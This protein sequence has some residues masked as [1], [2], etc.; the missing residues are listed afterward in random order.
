MVIIFQIRKLSLR[1][2]LK[3][4]GAT[5]YLILE[6]ALKPMIHEGNPTDRGTRGQGWSKTMTSARETIIT[7]KEYEGTTGEQEFPL[8][9]AIVHYTLG[10]ILNA[11]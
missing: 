9:M 4:L 2:A 3:F 7:D 11:L 8:L 10:R 5:R 6:I 1:K